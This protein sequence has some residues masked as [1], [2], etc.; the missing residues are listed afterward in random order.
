MPIRTP[1]AVL[2][3]MLPMP[4]GGDRQD[5]VPA[6]HGINFGAPTTQMI[7]LSGARVFAVGDAA[8]R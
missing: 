2:A 8:V 1:L 4:E 5:L 3:S 6:G 7:R